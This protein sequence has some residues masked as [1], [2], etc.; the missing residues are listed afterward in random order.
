MCGG[1]SVCVRGGEGFIIR[2][3]LLYFFAEGQT[4]LVGEFQPHTK[5]CTEHIKILEF[6]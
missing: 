2:S 4:R 3:L 6:M 1:V 5:T